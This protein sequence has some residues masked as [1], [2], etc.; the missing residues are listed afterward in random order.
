MMATGTKNFVIQCLDF[1]LKFSSLNQEYL[2]LMK[3]FEFIIILVFIVFGIAISEVIISIGNILRQIDK[4]QFYPPLLL[5][6]MAGWMLTIQYFFSLY[7][8]QKVQEWSVRNFGIL[9]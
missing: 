4:V 5:W 1:A 7:R 3:P 2:S 6:M 9:L 8:L